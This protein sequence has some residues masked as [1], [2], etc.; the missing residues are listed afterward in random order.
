MT[1]TE[2]L[3]VEF[4]ALSESQKGLVLNFVE[5]LNNHYDPGM[6]EKGEF[7]YIPC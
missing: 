2:R 5:F 1:D 3:L 7:P 6:N 4:E